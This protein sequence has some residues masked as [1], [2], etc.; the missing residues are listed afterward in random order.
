MSENIRPN[1]YERKKRELKIV[2]WGWSL[3]VLQET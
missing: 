3:K 2:A 1:D